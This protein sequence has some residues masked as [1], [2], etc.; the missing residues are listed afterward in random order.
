MRKMSTT[1]AIEFEHVSK[2]FV[3]HHERPHSFQEMVI[4]LFRPRRRDDQEEFWALKDVSFEVPRAETIGLIGPNGSGKSTT[5]KLIARILEPTSGQI[6]VNGRVSTLLE[7]GAGFHPDL[8]GRENVYLNGSIHGLQRREI[9]ER[10]QSIV[11]FA[12]LEPFIDVQVRHYS[13]GMYVRLAFAVAA[14][15]DPDILLVDE[16]L[17][18]GDH[19]FQMKCLDRIRELQRRGVTIVFVSHDLSMVEHLCSHAI[20]LHQGR[21]EARG[22]PAEVVSRYLADLAAAEEARLKEEQPPGVE[23]RW[24]SREVEITEVKFLDSHGQERR[25]FN[26]GDTMIARIEYQAPRRVERP[27]F[28]VAIHRRDGLHIAGPNTKTSGY[29]IDAVEGRGAIDFIMDQLALREG[30]YQ[31]T[32]T[33]YDYDCLHPYDHHERA[34]TFRVNQPAEREIL[35]MLDLPCRWEQR[36]L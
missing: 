20:L 26:V 19:S 17:A 2:K 7:L 6:R 12:E 16:T 11:S 36:T 24:G 13:S 30:V 29:E 21:V 35:G 5:L 32:A 1:T 28:G 8:T 31:F 14:H 18:V 15:I 9:E 23:H 27:V 10:F 33:V 3:L 22:R 34:Y 25:T 4:D